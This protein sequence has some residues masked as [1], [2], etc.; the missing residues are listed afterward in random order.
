MIGGAGMP[1]AQNLLFGTA[2][3]ALVGGLDAALWGNDIGK[4]MLWGAAGGAVST[5]LTSE[6]FSF[7]TKGKGFYNNQTVL[8][9]FK[10]GKYLIPTGSTWQQEALNHFG[11]E[12]TYRPSKPKGGDN[13]DSDFYIGSVSPTTKQISFGDDAFHSYTNG[14]P[15]PNYSNLRGTYEKE[16]F[17]QKR[18]L[19]GKGPLI[20]EVSSL[21]YYP[22]EALGF[23]QA[24]RNFG[25]FPNSTVNYLNQANSYWS[26]VYG[27]NLINDKAWYNFIYKIPRRW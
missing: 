9:N 13:V 27:T 10:T 3:G 6:N 5:T 20:S 21:R 17:T 26:Q 19:N 11:F 15:I 1:F 16:L 24:F 23:R 22:E 18:I 4:G 8:E 2:E 7:W 14:N 25:L 12:G